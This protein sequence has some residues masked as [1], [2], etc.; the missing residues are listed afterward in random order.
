MADEIGPVDGPR[1]DYNPPITPANSGS[2]GFGPDSKSSSG[3]RPVSERLFPESTG[4][5]GPSRESSFDR[6]YDTPMHED[7]DFL[8]AG[9]IPVSPVSPINPI[10][11]GHSDSTAKRRM[12]D[13]PRSPN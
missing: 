3:T 11:L 8:G 6:T 7:G 10:G 1:R 9:Q 2:T 12:S 4:L 5:T 13:Q